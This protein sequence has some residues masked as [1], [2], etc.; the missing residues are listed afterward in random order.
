M[1]EAETD[2]V[3][4][5]LFLAMQR[6]DEKW[7]REALSEARH[8]L[9]GGDGAGDDVPVGAVVVVGGQVVGRGRNEVVL[10]RDPTLHAEMV[11][12][13]SAMQALTTPRL[14]SAT[15]FVTLEPCAMCAGALWLCRIE[16]IVFGAFDA[17]AGACGSLFDIA[18]DVR[19]N[20]RPQVRGGVLAD[21]SQ[22]LL[23][24]FFASRRE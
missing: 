3:F 20:H 24:D 9:R 13:R 6:D 10:R 14:E 19:L 15:L 12:L 2:L 22:T 7:M 16:R 23:R 8:C 11:A 5:F 21:E 18:R 17:K 1:W 4:A